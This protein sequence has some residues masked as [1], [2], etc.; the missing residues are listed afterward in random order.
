MAPSKKTWNIIIVAQKTFAL[1]WKE[2]AELIAAGAVSEIM[3]RV[4]PCR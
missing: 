3:C 2:Y 4:L 1:F